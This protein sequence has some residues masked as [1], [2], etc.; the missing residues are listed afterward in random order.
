MTG[1]LV[2][3]VKDKA[4]K[5]RQK[6]DENIQ[7]LDLEA[8][9][10]LSSTLVRSLDTRAKDF[11]DLPV[12]M[13]G[14][15]LDEARKKLTI[16]KSPIALGKLREIVGDGKSLETLN[17]AELLALHSSLDQTIA[18]EA[19]RLETERGELEKAAS[20]FKA[21]ALAPP[22]RQEPVDSYR[23]NLQS[24][25]D[26]LGAADQAKARRALLIGEPA[27]DPSPESAPAKELFSA[28]DALAAALAATGEPHLAAVAAKTRAYQDEIEAAEKALAQSGC[29]CGFGESGT[30]YERRCVLSFAGRRLVWSSNESSSCGGLCEAWKRDGDCLRLAG[31]GAIEQRKEE[32]KAKKRAAETALARWKTK[33]APVEEAERRVLAARKALGQ[34]EETPPKKP[35]PPAKRPPPPPPDDP[36]PFRPKLD[37]VA[38]CPAKIGTVVMHVP[39]GS[40]VDVSGTRFYAPGGVLRVNTPPLPSCRSVYYSVRVW[41]PTPHG[42]MA[43]DFTVSVTP[44]YLSEVYL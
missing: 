30:Y 15:I 31:S 42:T 3:D 26:A 21:K 41:V 32:Q 11:S 12:A 39:S 13:S 23:A 44:G 29:D 1:K 20:G 40:T 37:P 2:F 38:D 4:L 33:V 6:L 14:P 28:A 10:R 22:P 24:W 17:P 7:A 9:R 34:E 36:A 43:R 16:G 35:A 8:R 5:L 27:P 18:N 25:L 19:T